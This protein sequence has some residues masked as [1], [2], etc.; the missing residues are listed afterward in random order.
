VKNKNMAIQ[1]LVYYH[2][3]ENGKY[4]Q[5]IVSSSGSGKLLAAA[6]LKHLPAQ[7]TNGA[8]VILVEHQ[9][10]NPELDRWI[11]EMAANPQNPAL[12]LYFPEISTSCLWKALRLGARE[13]FT[14]PIKEEEFQQALDRVI[15]RAAVTLG[16]AGP[17]RIVSFMGCKG[18]VGTTFLAANSAYLLARERQ[19]Q[20]LL[21]DLDLQYG[22]LAYFFDIRPQQTLGDAVNHFEEL[23][24]T[25]LKSIL[26]PRDK[27]L[28]ILPAPARP[29]EGESI[30]PEH[31]G[32]LLG[33][34]KKLPGFSW[35]IIDA[36]HQ[37]DEVTLK[38]VEL[39]DE[40][41]LVATPTIPALAN[42][43]KLLELLRRLGLERLAT[44]L[45]LN[46]WQKDE[47]LTLE[48]V[49]K[50]LERDVSGTIRYDYREVARSINEGRPLAET[51][52]RHP[53]CL[54]LKA[55]VTKIKGEEAPSNGNGLAWSWLKWLG[56]GK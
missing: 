46:A 32:K 26:Y 35:I 56:G 3:P 22:Q 42:A 18:G 55:L 49:S 51:A 23:D 48:E 53:L 47:D 7:G 5:Q 1:F 8:D 25:Y 43:K 19:G 30:S 54:D 33:N 17:P 37:F 38:A 45:W 16:T 34:A 10:N 40:L 29:E 27:H 24:V 39:S 6:D 50:F 4:L 2:S 41:I 20:V 21:M 15:S 36:G 28:Q 13:C 9:E 31:V 12:F 44:E 14:Y 11:E 52:P